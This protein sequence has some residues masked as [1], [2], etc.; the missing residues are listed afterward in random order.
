MMI[1]MIMMV[2]MISG[3]SEDDDANCMQ[4]YPSKLAAW[5]H[6]DASTILI[7]QLL[8]SECNMALTIN[9]LAKLNKYTHES[10]KYCGTWISVVL[11]N[12]VC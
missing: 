11:G 2:M 12:C 8:S 1:V 9:Q 6:Q 3:A 5:L 7:K 10:D 4:I